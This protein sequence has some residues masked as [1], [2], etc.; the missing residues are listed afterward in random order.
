[1]LAN[2]SRHL[3]LAHSSVPSREEG[4]EK[5]TELATNSGAICYTARR[6]TAKKGAEPLHSDVS[7]ISLRKQVGW[8]TR[9]EKTQMKKRSQDYL[10]KQERSTLPKA[11]IEC[12]CT[13]RRRPNSYPESFG[14]VHSD[15]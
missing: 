14:D 3:G 12:P 4:I 7:G 9:S 10:S 2:Q 8:P 11:P 6:D 1:M 15:V 13:W 5:E